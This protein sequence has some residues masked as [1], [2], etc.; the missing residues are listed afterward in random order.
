MTELNIEP[1]LENAQMGLW[2]MEITQSDPPVCRMRG[3]RVMQHLLALSN[4]EE[5][6]A[7]YAFWWEHIHPSYVSYI[8][9]AIEY[10]KTHAC[11]EVEYPW[12]HPEKGW[13]YIRCG[14]S[15]LQNQNGVLSLQGYHQDVTDLLRKSG[16]LGQDYQ[17]E[18]FYKFK[19]YA[20]YFMD[21]YEEMNEVDPDTMQVS[22]IFVRK[23]R[24]PLFEEQENLFQIAREN[25]HPQDYDNFCAFIHA[26]Q[27]NR[28]NRSLELRIQML[29]TTYLW[30]QMI[31]TTAMLNGKEKWLLCFHDIDASRKAEEMTKEREALLSA[32]A[33]EN[34]H[35]LDIDLVLA[36]VRDIDT[37][38]EFSFDHFLTQLYP[39]YQEEERHRL[40]AF[41]SKEKLQET[42]R[43]KKTVYIDVQRQRDGSFYGWDRMTLV[44]P[45]DM[46]N[47]LLLLIKTMDEEYLMQVIL[48]QYIE[49]NFEVLCLIECKEKFL[50]PFQIQS[51]NL[52]ET[53]VHDY[54][55]ITQS[56]IDRFVVPEERVRARCNMEIEK[57]LRHLR[58]NKLYY[59][60]VG[61]I[62]TKGN[63]R[64][65]LFQYHYY[66]ASSLRILLMVSDISK[67]YKLEQEEKK[68][69]EAMAHK[70]N[71][72]HLT[73]LFNRYYCETKIHTYLQEE[74]AHS[75]SA[76]LL[77]DLDDFKKI[78]DTFGHAAGDQALR[79]VSNLLQQYFRST[80][81]IARF[82]GDEFVVFMKDIRDKTVLPKLMNR[83]LGQLDFSYRTETDQL[84][85]RASI[86]IAL[87]PE[88]GMEM[89]VL[90]QKADKAL[91]RI[92]KQGKRGYA[93]YDAQK[94]Q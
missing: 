41:F 79:D 84:H 68:K 56:Y 59:F 49:K 42:L 54:T 57:I 25:V 37:A 76:F 39:V 27:K 60:S 29:D 70:A 94:D 14:A 22:R 43:K 35:M 63:Q 77:I 2:T 33:K 4:P 11:V 64:R 12:Y 93:I 88:N 67:Q 48:T 92:K 7:M 85:L 61:I 78:N 20:S 47:R 23:D 53:E 46:E 73:G 30:V 62:D 69:M 80:D 81:I 40:S 32:V 82:G 9:D 36:R 58:L 16:T 87:A 90:Y 51:N 45:K 19:K 65:M 86:G 17:I 44:V 1:V 34:A 18:D 83:L 66:D 24:Y 89:D 55:R 15:T 13:R 5:P 50:I 6:E 74:G 21:V 10:L 75:C 71:T 28:E 72:D 91:Y 38:R 31:I 3:N 26:W 52:L 8:L